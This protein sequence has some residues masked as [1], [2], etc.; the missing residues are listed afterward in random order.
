MVVIATIHAS[1]LNI[2]IVSEHFSVQSLIRNIFLTMDVLLQG[3]PLVAQMEQ[4]DRW[5]LYI[6]RYGI[7]LT[8]N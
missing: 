2:E 1:K 8:L 3:I 7:V 4:D 5:M 6:A